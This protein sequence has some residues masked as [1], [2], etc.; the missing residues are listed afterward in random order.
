MQQ[1]KSKFELLREK[2]SL[3]FLMVIQTSVYLK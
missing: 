1:E 2:V 3:P